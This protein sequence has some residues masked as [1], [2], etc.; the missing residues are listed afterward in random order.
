[1]SNEF[2]KNQARQRVS[3]G[4]SDN[5]ARAREEEV[6]SDN[7]RD[8]EGPASRSRRSLLALLL[9]LVFARARYL[10]LSRTIIMTNRPPLID[11]LR[12]FDFVR[13]IKR[14][15]SLLTINN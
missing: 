5:R 4:V 6:C 10:S 13:D 3:K 11:T 12:A 15:R 14:E 8:G 9:L 7:Q 2:C 1:M